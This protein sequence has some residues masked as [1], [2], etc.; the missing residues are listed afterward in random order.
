[1]SKR[2]VDAWFAKFDHPLKK[3]MQRVRQIILAADKRMD[4]CIKWSSPTFTFEGNLA[5][6]NPRTKKHVSLMFHSGAQIP[7]KHPRLLGGGDTARYMTFADIA[8]VESSRKDLQAVVR[9][10]CKLKSAQEA[11]P[12]AKKRRA[13]RI[14]APRKLSRKKTARRT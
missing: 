4:E 8:E 13:R 2:E 7:G 11:R 6:F 1:M 5:S 10:W 12:A 9:A 3:A 14:S